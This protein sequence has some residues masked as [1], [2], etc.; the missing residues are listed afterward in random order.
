MKFKGGGC[1][2]T[3]GLVS[4]ISTMMLLYPFLKS[5]ASILGLRLLELEDGL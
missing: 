4:H 5:E 3:V 2:V 1:L